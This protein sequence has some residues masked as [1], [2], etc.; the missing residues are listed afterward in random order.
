MYMEREAILDD[1]D[2]KSIYLKNEKSGAECDM[3]GSFSEI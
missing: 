1:R 3:E 2:Y